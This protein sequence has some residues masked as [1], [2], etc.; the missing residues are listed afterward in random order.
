MSGDIDTRRVATEYNI[1]DLLTKSLVKKRI[2]QLVRMMGLTGLD[3]NE[4]QGEHEAPE[5]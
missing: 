2:D 3:E 5:P 4:N 1:A